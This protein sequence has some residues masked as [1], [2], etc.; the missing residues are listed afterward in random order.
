MGLTKKT[1]S[2]MEDTARLR[3]SETS[4]ITR[5]TRRMRGTSVVSLSPQSL[6][7]AVA[8]V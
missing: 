4:V 6:L 5:Q 3:T 1:A 2:S 8:K 7:E